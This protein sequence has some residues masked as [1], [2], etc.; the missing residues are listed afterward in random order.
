[1]SPSI[2]DEIFWTKS[3]LYAKN[4]VIDPTIFPSI[5]PIKGTNTI[6]FILI[7]FI[8]FINSTVPNP[9]KTKDT[10]IFCI[11]V[12]PGIIIIQN[13]IPSLAKSA[14]AAVVGET[15]LFLLICCIIKPLILN[16]TPATIIA[17]SLGNLLISNISILSILKVNISLILILVT[18]INIEAIHN[19]INTINKY[20]FF[21]CFPPYCLTLSQKTINNSIWNYLLIDINFH[22][23]LTHFIILFFYCL[24]IFSIFYIFYFL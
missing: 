5:I 17:I 18:P 9:A 14:V 3:Y 13:K 21:I 24:G 23:F 16:P 20:L 22:L 2:H 8:I 12:A 11:I 6:F 10:I 1:M 15:N 19:I 4:V 7:A